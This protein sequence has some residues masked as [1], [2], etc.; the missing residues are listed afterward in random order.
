M[1]N[2]IEEK[3]NVNN[4]LSQEDQKAKEYLDGVIDGLEEELRK[5]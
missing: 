4:E 3:E 1:N 2:V 5:R